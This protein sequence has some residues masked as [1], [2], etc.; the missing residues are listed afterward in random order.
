[1]TLQPG[2]ITLAPGEGL[3]SGACSQAMRSEGLPWLNSVCVWGG[4][5]QEGANLSPVICSPHTSVHHR[6][7]SSGQ[8]GIHSGQS[9]RPPQGP[10]SESG[11]PWLR[12][13][14]QAPARL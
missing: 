6:Q 7:A 9:L 10:V 3:W 4:A 12:N 14:S 2:D 8:A 11:G 1:M 13:P 5:F